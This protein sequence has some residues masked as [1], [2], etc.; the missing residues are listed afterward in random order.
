M[1]VLQSEIVQVIK[2][3]ICVYSWLKVSQ[4]AL[5]RGLL[6]GLEERP[7]DAPLTERDLTKSSEIKRMSKRLEYNQQE[8]VCRMLI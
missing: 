3:A 8:T 5:T 4:Q 6:S 1:L 2:A 7:V